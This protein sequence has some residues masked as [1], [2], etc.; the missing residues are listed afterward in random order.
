[1]DVQ[2]CSMIKKILMEIMATNVIAGL[3]DKWQ[4][5]AKLTACAKTCILQL[6]YC[7]LHLATCILHLAFCI[8]HL[9]FCILHF[10]F[11]ILYFAF[12]ILHLTSCKFSLEG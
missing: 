8:L 9:A 10:A 2:E 7:N 1:M 3:P 12:C 4:P 5:T 6:V 11:C